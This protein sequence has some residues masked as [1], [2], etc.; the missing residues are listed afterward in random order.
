M[1]DHLESSIFGDT[2]RSHRGGGSGYPDHD[3]HGHD[4]RGHHDHDGHDDRRP[5][6][7]RERR[8]E[9][10]HGRTKPPLWRR[11]LVIVVA[12]AVVGGGAFAAFT[13][14]RP[15]VEGALESN[16][17]P[18]PGSGEVVIKVATGANGSAIARQ[19][20]SQDVIKSTKAFN[21]AASNDPRS[22]GIQPGSYTL[23]KQMKASDALAVLVDPANR[24]VT[25]V[26][27]QEGLWAKEIYAKLSQATGVPVAQ[28]TAAAKN[29]SALGLP[30]SAKGN[31][32]GYLFP[33][34]YEFDSDTTAAEQLKTMV[35]ESVK[36]LEALGVS[37]ANMERVVIIA[38]LVEAESRDNADRP[39]VARVVENRLADGMRLQFDST[40]S[41][42]VGRRSMTTT[43]AERADDNPYNTYLKDGLPAGPI[44]NPGESAIEAAAKPAAGNWTYFVT[45]N[46]STGATKFTN[47]YNQHLAN[48]KEFQA[49]CQ[50]NKGQC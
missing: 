39:K 17:Y 11:L 37:S 36:R 26:T 14:L 9:R 25:R 6:S 12:L 35:A 15:V 27:I 18:G 4:D 16:D 22:A 24:D 32:E 44:D 47:D 5:L 42:G 23:K 34:S 8:A 2:D 48:V 7:R 43:D 46:P 30:P 40:V 28:Y 45:V 31:V 10:R 13:V 33:A 20:L 38:S 29:A 1:T 41:Y 21:E 3:D 49:W 50:A 19:L